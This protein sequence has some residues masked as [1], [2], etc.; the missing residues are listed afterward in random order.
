MKVI[1][2]KYGG[3]SVATTDK[4][5]FIANKIKQKGNEQKHIVVVSAMGKTTDQLISLAKEISEK[6]IAR[7]MDM[8]L[9]TGEQVSAS[10]LSIALNE[11]GVITISL[12]GYQAG[13][14][15]TADHMSVRILSI[16][17]EKFNNLLNEYDA[18]VVTGF[19]GV[20]EDNEITTLGRG[21]SDT[22]AVALA[23]ELGYNVEIYSDVDGIYTTDPR[24]HPNAK[25]L[26]YI[27][28]DEMLELAGSGAKVLH[29]RSVEIAKKYNIK[30]YCAA[31]FSN[32]E[33]SYVVNEELLIES[34]VV[35]GLSVMENQVQVSIKD[36]PLD[37][38]IIHTIFEKISNSGFN[39]DM[40]SVINYENSLAVSFTVIRDV[41]SEILEMLY[42][43][44]KEYESY[45]VEYHKDFVKVSIVGIGMK[46]ATG[47][48]TRFFN[49]LKDIPIRLVT[50]S[51]IKI[52]ALIETKFKEQAVEALV[53]E[54]NL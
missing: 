8:L 27:S 47:V 40:I 17:K 32:E 49:A 24:L 12:N 11:I 34:P 18:I 30:I 26:K 43:T 21:G 2:Q 9:T 45:N 14:L 53:K 54:F 13:I 41:K 37:Y 25:K 19:Q 15:T 6:P 48:A 7:E 10:L 50:T 1:V 52:S 22:S 3:S 20:T 46:S 39:V 31:T 4:I 36:L 23:A 29:S 5:K 35:S 42:E 51:E 28:Y 38:T 33:G 44:L 16:D